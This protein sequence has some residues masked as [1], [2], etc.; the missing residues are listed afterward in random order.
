VND[1]APPLLLGGFPPAMK[2]LTAAFRLYSSSISRLFL[3]R[4]KRKTPPAIAATATSPTTTPAAMPALLGPPLDD[5]PKLVADAVGEPLAVTT[6]VCPPTVTTDGLAVVVCE[7]MLEADEL[8]A[9]V[10]TALPTLLS[11]PVR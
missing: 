5:D 3:L 4:K 2:L 7:G 6:M 11:K 1:E 9:E 8:E 10:V